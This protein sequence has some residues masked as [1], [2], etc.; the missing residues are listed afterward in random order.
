MKEEFEKLKKLI[1]SDKSIDF[2]PELADFKDPLKVTIVNYAAQQSKLNRIPKQYKT[3]KYLDV[4]NYYKETAWHFIA[5]TKQWKEV[6]LPTKEQMNSQMENGLTVWHCA[7]LRDKFKH[8]PIIDDFD[9]INVEQ[10]GNTILHYLAKS[11][12]LIP[13]SWLT[14]ENLQVKNNEHESVL[15]EIVNR[16]KLCENSKL[17]DI[18]PWKLL[19]KI[20][21]AKRFVP[22]QDL[23]DFIAIK[24]KSDPSKYFDLIK[25]ICIKNN[26]LSETIILPKSVIEIKSFHL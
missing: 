15:S 3:S 6:P 10:N 22:R 14:S 8:V 18:V 7:A 11:P 19:H 5:V 26:I 16:G 23:A 2:S 12:S 13:D 21:L 1:D 25:D 4:P 17:N 9:K 24:N 20:T